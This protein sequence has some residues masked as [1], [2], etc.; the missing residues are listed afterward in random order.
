MTLTKNLTPYI[1]TNYLLESNVRAININKV[2]GIINP[3]AK[4]VINF[5]GDSITEGAV[6]SP[7]FKDGGFAGLL[8][9]YLQN[10]YGN[11]G[12]GYIPYYYPYDNPLMSFTGSWAYNNGFG[13]TNIYAQSTPNTGAYVEFDIN[14]VGVEIYYAQGTLAGTYE[15]YSDGVLIDTIDT[16]N[17]TSNPINSHITSGLSDGIHHIKLLNTGLKAIFLLGF[18][19][20]KSGSIG[21]LTN[22]CAKFGGRTA[23]A[24]AVNS[25]KSAEYFNPN[26]TI[27]A[28]LA[29][30]ANDQ[31]AI[32]TYTTNLIALVNSA[33][34]SGQVLLIANGIHYPTT[35]PITEVQYT[36]AMRAVAIIKGCA[37]VDINYAWGYD[38]YIANTLSYMHDGVHPNSSGH[39]YIYNIIKYMIGEA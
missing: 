23:D 11:L 33:Q 27:I 37:F 32:D 21:V 18:R 5:V 26:L 10:K 14:G 8:R 28:F 36:N 4:T 38:G 34:K 29:N 25:L 15:V 6:G 1:N 24:S 3:A 2:R 16:Y 9:N 35:T 31:L 20:V 7:N 12:G 30:D 22:M 39:N 17:A 13:T 19:E